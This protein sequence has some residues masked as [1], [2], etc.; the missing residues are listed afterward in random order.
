VRAAAHVLETQ[1][2]QGLSV[3]MLH[4]TCAML[5]RGIA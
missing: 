2:F 4:R 1:Y 5:Q 3:N